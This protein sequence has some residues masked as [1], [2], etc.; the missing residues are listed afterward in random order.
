MP[1]LNQILAP[2]YPFGV[3]FNLLYCWE[4]YLLL[5][6]ALGSNPTTYMDLRWSTDITIQPAP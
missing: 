2:V 3:D 6:D 1:S 5:Y 4:G